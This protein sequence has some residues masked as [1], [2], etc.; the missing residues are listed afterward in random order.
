MDQLEFHLGYTQ[1]RGRSYLGEIIMNLWKH[2]MICIL[3]F[4]AGLVDAISGGGG[5][6]SLPAYTFAGLPIHTAIATNKMSSSMGTTIA[7]VKY[8][9]DGFVPW[10]LV[11]LCIIGAFSGSSL[12][13]NLALMVSDYYFKIMLL[14][15]VPLAAYYVLKSKHLSD[16]GELLINKKNIICAGLISFGVG[17]YDGFY[18]PG[19]G[20]FLILLLTMLTHMK[21]TNANGLTKVINWSTNV[22]AL[23]IFMINAKVMIPL[24]ILA[25]TFNIVGNYI[26]ANLF[27]KKSGKYTRPFLLLILFLFYIKLISEL[28]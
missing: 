11:P 12:G 7:T 10:K 19:T 4:I 5:L 9:K 25:G 27:S 20:T 18:G 26:G 2:I 1:E 16:S 22:S 13:A 8:I 17:I 21:L 6:I 15:I 14:V 28:I 23:A 24:G 3:V